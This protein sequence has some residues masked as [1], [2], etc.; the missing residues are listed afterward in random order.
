M[1]LI[2]FDIIYKKKIDNASIKLLMDSE[3]QQ[4]KIMICGKYKIYDINNLY[5]Y[6]KNNQ[7]KND[8]LTKIKDIFK[9][10]RVK[11]EIKDTPDSSPKNDK[12]SRDS[13][14]NYNCEQNKENKKKCF[15]K[16]KSVASCVCDRC[17]ELLCDKCSRK[18]KHLGHNNSIIKLNEYQKHFKTLF[19]KNAVELD[20]KIINAEEYKFLKYWEYD[21]TR[22]INNIDHIYEFIKKQLED[23][24]KIQIDYI[25]SLGQNNKYDLLKQQ[26]DSVINQFE[27]INNNIVNND[28]VSY[29]KLIENKKIVINSSQDILNAYN[30]IK[31]HLLLYTKAIKEIEIFNNVYMKYACDKFNI[32]K[33]NYSQI[34]I[35]NTSKN[36]IF[37]SNNNSITNLNINNNNNNFSHSTSVSNINNSIAINNLNAIACSPK[38]AYIKNDSN[39]NILE[40]KKYLS[41]ILNKNS[42]DI[43]G[44]LDMEQ[45]DKDKDKDKNASTLNN[46]SNNVSNNISNNI[47]HNISNNLNNNPSL[48]NN[49]SSSLNQTPQNNNDKMIF[50]LKNEQKIIIFSLNTMGFKEKNYVDKSD[51]SKEINAD[52]EVIQINLFNKLFLLAGKDF[53]KFY[54]YDTYSNGI[55]YLCN[56][57][58]SHYFGSF[59]FCNKYNMLYLLGGNAEGNNEI[60][61]INNNSKKVSWNKLPPFNEERQEFASIYIDDYIYIFFGFSSKLQ[62]NLSSIERI[63]VNT[64][65]KF[66]VVYINE[67]I[68]LSCLG[69]AKFV[70]DGEQGENKE[71]ILLLGGF[72]GANYIDTSLALN[73]QEMKIRDCE[74]IIPNINKHFQ[75]LF[76][77]ESAFVEIEPGIQI[78]FDMKNNVHLLTKESYELFTEKI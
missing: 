16:C 2:T 32:I 10:Q 40:N 61:Y 54:Y 75:F 23:I 68:S 78:I 58:Y 64:N 30:E 39:T 57:L 19:N 59:V 71:C 31:E 12:K 26:I 51:F 34:P 3:F 73:L 35:T 28:S 20:K 45:K 33:K 29:E 49:N 50:K 38:I 46:I 60:C 62:S 11:I 77:K 8:D 37:L 1:N 13:N 74:I 70:E 66:E 41:P 47:S 27:N 7:L 65:D 44:F 55:F 69:C 24:K 56:T 6:Y 53:N 22:E 67:Q 48:F 15:C 17:N 14:N 63:N 43:L 52:L 25:V 72:N 9:T 42:D 36:N 76:Q 18:N 21:V 4:L 5:I